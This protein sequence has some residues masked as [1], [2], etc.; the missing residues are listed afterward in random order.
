MNVVM[1]DESCEEISMFTSAKSCTESILCD[2]GANVHM[3]P[4]VKDLQ[5]TRTI[6]RSCTFGNKGQ[7]KASAL[8]EMPL[9]V[10]VKGKDDLTEVT[11]KNVLWVPGIPC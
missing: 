9:R 4:W 8:G 5:N 11:L 6:N 1:E 2:S 7:L 10:K 3:T